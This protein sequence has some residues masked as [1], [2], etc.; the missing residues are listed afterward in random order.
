M[1]TNLDRDDPFSKTNVLLTCHTSTQTYTLLLP[2]PFATLFIT[3]P[4]YTV[5]L[6]SIPD[7]HNFTQTCCLPDS[8]HKTQQQCKKI[9]KK[10]SKCEPQCVFMSC[11]KMMELKN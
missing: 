10:V 2:H 11:N 9:S 3:N 8:P 1:V 4:R 7:L 6:N 5:A